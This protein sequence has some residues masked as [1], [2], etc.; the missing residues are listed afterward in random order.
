MLALAILG[1]LATLGYIMSNP[2]PGEAFTEFYILGS[3]VK[4]IDYPSELMVGEE[5]VLLGIINREHEAETYH[6]EILIEGV[7]NKELGPVELKPDER[8][9]VIVDF[10][11]ARAGERQKLEF[12]LYRQGQSEVYQGLYLW[13]DVRWNLVM[14][15]KLTS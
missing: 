9:E 3:G 4:D 1:S 6:V 2:R 13:V 14:P 8:W 15:D 5:E 11:S 7:K 10:S 12:L